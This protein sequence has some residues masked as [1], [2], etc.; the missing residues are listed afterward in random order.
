MTFTTTTLLTSRK[1]ISVCALTAMMALGTSNIAHA[2]GVALGSTRLIYPQGAKQVSMTVSNSDKEQTFLIQSWI[3]TAEGKKSDDFV[4]TP[5]LFA[6]KPAKDNVLRVLYAGPALPTDK[7]TLFYFNSKAIPS[8]DKGQIQGN[9]LQ[10]ATQSVIKLFI[11]PANLAVKSADAPAMLR[12][13]VSGGTLKMTNPSP[14]Y[15]TLVNLTVDGKKLPNTMVPPMGEQSVKSPAG[16]VAFQTMND[17]GAI[18]KK[19]ACQ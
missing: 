14:Y 8:V 7:E 6:L 16:A 11:R 18:T 1:I 19:Q 3:S 17:F 4:V 12:C 9:T 10:I 15:I 2:G 13:Q 5:P